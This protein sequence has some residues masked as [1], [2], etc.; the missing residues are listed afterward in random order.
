M[1][2]SGTLYITSMYGYKIVLLI[3]AVEAA[4]AEY[5]PR[6]IRFCIS[7][8]MAILF[9]LMSGASVSAIRGG[10]MA[11]LLLLAKE[12]GNVF[13]R[14]NAL[15]FAAFAIALADPTQVAQAGFL[16]SFASAVGMVILVEPLRKFLRL[17]VGKGMF[18]WKSAVILS[19]SSLLPVIPL[20]CVFF[21]SFSLTAIFA[22]ILVSPVIP[23]GMALGF[24]LA[25]AGFISRFISFLI[26]PA[27][28][29][30]LGYVLWII[31]FFAAH[32]VPLP[33]RFT[34]PMPFVLYYV[35]LISFAYAHRENR[36]FP[37][38]ADMSA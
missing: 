23:L 10:I 12:T 27:A 25:S 6:R 18:G 14:R 11:C 9:V 22:N 20:V 7:A 29:V 13:S 16:F 37:P 32:T 35:A 31:H 15:A 19:V 38:T 28:G 34:D 4:L 24:T 5:V 26:G 30:V 3:F 21:G 17:G 36:K 8:G 1:A 33:F 2:T